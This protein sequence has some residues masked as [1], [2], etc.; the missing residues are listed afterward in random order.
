MTHQESPILPIEDTPRTDDRTGGFVLVALGLLFFLAQWIDLGFLV[1]PLLALGFLA[2]GLLRREIGFLIPGGILGGLS[3]GLWLLSGPLA[4]LEGE[5]EAATFMLS[6]ALGWYSIPL[7]SR[8]VGAEPQWWALIPGTIMAIIGIALL[9]GGH[10]LALLGTGWPLI[11]VAV[12]L[13][14]LLRRNG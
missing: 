4:G 11:L 8:L 7:L 10:A 6:F 3:L 14:T 5:G 13:A 9:I 2:A 1:L 12:G